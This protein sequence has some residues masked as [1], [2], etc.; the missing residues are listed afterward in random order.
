MRDREKML[1]KVQISDFEMIEANLYLD[2][3]PYCNKALQYFYEAKERADYLRNEFEEK[4]GPLT[5]SSNRCD[6]WEWIN[7]PWPWECEG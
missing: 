1:K 3:Y 5:A 7:S 6:G 2:A 4:Y